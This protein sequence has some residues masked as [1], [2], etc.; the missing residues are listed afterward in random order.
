[1]DE[2]GKNEVANPELNKRRVICGRLEYSSTERP[3][4]GACCDTLKG[5]ISFFVLKF[6]LPS[7]I[8][9]DLFALVVL[10]HE[11]LLFISILVY[12]YLGLLLVMKV[13]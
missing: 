4:S 9:G 10:F 12:I 5:R 8:R 7:L 6:H 3:F 13:L 1:M 11:V 2:G